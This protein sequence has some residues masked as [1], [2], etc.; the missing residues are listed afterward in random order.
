MNSG[1]NVIGNVTV[2]RYIPNHYKAWQFLAAP[3]N[4]QSINHAWQEGNLPLA[5][6]HPGYGT[7]LTSPVAGAVFLGFDIYSPAAPS[8]KTYNPATN[9][10]DGV[11]NP[12]MM[13]ANRKGYMLFVRGDRTVNAYNQPA[14]A[15]TLRTTG[16]LNTVGIYAPPTTTVLAGK[17]VETNSGRNRKL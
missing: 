16:Q 11:A 9:A 7:I 1:N 10:W 6:M 15:T 5:N 8:M 17:W 13:I 2:E 4:G 14:T 3:T 12:S